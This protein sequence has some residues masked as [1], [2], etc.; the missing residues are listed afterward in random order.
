MGGK[1]GMRDPRFVMH[2]TVA[3]TRSSEQIAN[4]ASVGP[5]QPHRR[6]A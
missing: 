2:H 4:M 3:V 5:R 1:D 6:G